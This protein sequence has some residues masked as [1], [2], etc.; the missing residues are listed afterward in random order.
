MYKA[1]DRVLVAITVDHMEHD[2]VVMRYDEGVEVWFDPR[3]IH[4][5]AQVSGTTAEHVANL[6]IASALLAPWEG[7]ARFAV[8]AAIAHML[9]LEAKV[10]PEPVDWNK[11]EKGTRVRVRDYTSEDWSAAS[12]VACDLDAPD[13]HYGARRDEDNQP[14]F[15]RLCELAEER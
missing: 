11:V 12:F 4:G 2:C 8:S 5:P 14:F 1:G 7:T 9:A 13:F 15:W 10:P 6:R 3:D